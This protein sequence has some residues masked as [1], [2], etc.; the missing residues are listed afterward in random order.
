[1]GQHGGQN[2]ILR[3][4][5]SRLILKQALTKGWKHDKVMSR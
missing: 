4:K 1:M 3:A 2:G 5:L